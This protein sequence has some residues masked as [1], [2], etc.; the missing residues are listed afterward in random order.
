MTGATPMFA[1]FVNSAWRPPIALPDLRRTSVIALDLET[2]DDRLV[3][4]M[5]SGWPFGAGHICGISIAYRQEGAIRALYFPLRHP[6]TVNFDRA[7]VFQWL[8]DLIASDVH[9]ITQAGLYDWGWLRAEADIRMPPAERLEEIGALATLVDENRFSYGLDALCAWRGL[10]GKDE[11][12]L[13]EAGA[14]Y[15]FPK[16]A[17]PQTYLWQLPA[18]RVGPYAEADA[19]NTLALWEDLDPILDREGGRDA[20]RLEIDLLPMVHE[21]RRRG[22]R[23]DVDAAEKARDHLLQ[24]RDAVFAELS[25]K[26]GANVGMAEIGRAKWLAETFDRHGIKYPRT[27]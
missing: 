18:R 25:E 3:A 2:R 9:I 13:K 4:D 23:I 22:I 26:L 24:K 12:L 20:Y 10:P 27:I 21:M 6:D 19:A 11:A 7:Q 1:E 15:G 14:A 5:G 16:R 8:K 17:K